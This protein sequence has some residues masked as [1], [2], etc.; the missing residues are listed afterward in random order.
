MAVTSASTKTIREIANKLKYKNSYASGTVKVKYNVSG[1]SADADGLTAARRNM[2]RDAFKYY[3]NFLGIGFAEFT[4][5]GINTISFQDNFIGAR[6]TLGPNASGQAT[7]KIHSNWDS[8]RTSMDSYAWYT[9]LHEIGHS[10]GLKHS[11]SYN[12]DSVTW[13]ADAEFWNDT[14]LLSSMSY[15]DPNDG[16]GVTSQREHSFITGS[17]LNNATMMASDYYALR[18]I[19]SSVA[20][21]DAHAGGTRLGFGTN[22]S[23]ASDPVWSQMV[24]NIRNSRF[25]YTD[26]ATSSYDT[27]DFHN[28][29]DNQR[30]DLRVTTDDM[31]DAYWSNIAGKTK[32]LAFADHSVF[33]CAIAGSGDDMIIGNYVDNHLVGKNGDDGIRGMAGDDKL[34]GGYGKDKLYGGSGDD[35]LKGGFGDDLLCGGRG[36]DHLNG[37]RGNDLLEGGNGDDLLIGGAGNDRL[38]G[39]LGRDTFRIQR[40]SGYTVVEDFA[41]GEDRIHLGHGLSGMS[42]VDR[43]DDAFVYYD[44]NIMACIVGAAGDLKLFGSYLV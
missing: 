30:I 40:G 35:Y 38:W 22:I 41:D 13:D 7:I 4:I 11:G 27:V 36:D 21:V 3:S 29:A 2:V 12:G 8:G 16:N 19:Y 37:G 39:Q 6:S 9:A 43:G 34:S 14:R 32:N 15:F 5:S 23:S 18:D 31:L 10:L 28:F 26:K 42:V 1:F 33:D 17:Y 44:S 20:H 24:A 25:F